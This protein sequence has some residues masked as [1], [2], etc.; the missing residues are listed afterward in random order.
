MTFIEFITYLLI[1]LI[2]YITQLLSENDDSINT[3]SVSDIMRI[4]GIC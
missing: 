2:L 3:L 1:R 4:C